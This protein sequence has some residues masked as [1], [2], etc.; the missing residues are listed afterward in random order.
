MRKGF[1]MEKRFS[2]KTCLSCGLQRRPQ[3]QTKTTTQSWGLRWRPQLGCFIKQVFVGVVVFNEDL[4]EVFNED[5]FYGTALCIL[6]EGRS[7]GKVFVSPTAQMRRIQR[8]HPM[9]AKSGS[10]DRSGAN[11]Q[12]KQNQAIMKLCFGGLCVFWKPWWSHQN[13]NSRKKLIQPL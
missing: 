9:E 7:R 6:W 12:I 13:C 8:I 1:K 11:L 10:W 2:T 4:F 5:L 3:L